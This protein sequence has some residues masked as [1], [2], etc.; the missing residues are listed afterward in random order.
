MN[1]ESLKGP[2]WS[3]G[4]ITA[5]K[6]VPICDYNTDYKI[7]IIIKI[8][9]KNLRNTKAQASKS[10]MRRNQKQLTCIRTRSLGCS[11]RNTKMLVS[12]LPDSRFLNGS[13]PLKLCQ[14]ILKPAFALFHRLGLCTRGKLLRMAGTLIHLF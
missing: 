8:E 6:T 5:A 3:K 4:L 13:P 10:K 14:T 7:I 9:K 11:F 2:N 12:V 1:K